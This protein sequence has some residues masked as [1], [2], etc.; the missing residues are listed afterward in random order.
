MCLTLLKSDLL[1]LRLL[2]KKPKFHDQREKQKHGWPL[3]HLTRKLVFKSSWGWVNENKDY[4]L[5]QCWLS[6]V[7][8]SLVQSASWVMRLLNYGDLSPCSGTM[9]ATVWKCSVLFYL[10]WQLY[11]NPQIVCF[12]HVLFH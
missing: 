9:S 1:N 11:S 3:V 2:F 6:S 12:Y 7:C 10:F 5:G 8:D 4:E